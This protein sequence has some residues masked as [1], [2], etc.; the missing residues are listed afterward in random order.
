MVFPCY[1]RLTALQKKVYRKSDEIISI[2]I[3]D[4]HKLH[5]V[6]QAL[7]SVLAREDKEEIEILSQKLISSLAVR[8]KTPPLRVKVLSARPHSDFGELHGLYVPAEGTKPATITVWMRTAQ[9]R[10]VAAFRTFL[11]TLLHEF[12]HHLD[13]EHFLLPESFHT[14]GFFKRESSMFHQLAAIRKTD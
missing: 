2:V 13:Y 5:S 3:P 12:C 7:V 8:L 10:K 4:A 14:E 1:G 6:V 11:G 9:K